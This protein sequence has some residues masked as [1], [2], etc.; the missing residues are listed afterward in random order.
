MK[1][2]WENVVMW[3]GLENGARCDVPSN[4]YY[5]SFS[6]LLDLLRMSCY[7]SGEKFIAIDGR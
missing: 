7:I 3:G 1:L 5:Q 4:I 6:C 2:V